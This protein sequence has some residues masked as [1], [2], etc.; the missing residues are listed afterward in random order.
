[1]L[2]VPVVDVVLLPV[3]GVALVFMFMGISFF[4]I[5][6]KKNCGNQLRSARAARVVPMAPL[7]G[8][9]PIAVVLAVLPFV[10]AGAVVVLPLMA[11]LARCAG[12]GAVRTT[13]AVSLR[14]T[15]CRLAVAASWGVTPSVAGADAPAAGMVVWADAPTTASAISAPMEIDLM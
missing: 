12:E 4:N 13:V 9:P 7:R 5:K 2:P 3:Y 14:G 15:A 1:M 11:S 6:N 10:A 8:V